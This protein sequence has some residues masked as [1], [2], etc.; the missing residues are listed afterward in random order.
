MI[1]QSED[2]KNG[3]HLIIQSMVDL[4]LTRKTIIALSYKNMKG[5]T[6]IPLEFNVN[7]EDI[8]ILIDWLKE[9][10]IDGNLVWHDNLHMD[11]VDEEKI[12]NF[13]TV[14]TTEDPEHDPIMFEFFFYKEVGGFRQSGSAS[15]SIF[16]ACGLLQK[17]MDWEEQ[18]V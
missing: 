2:N 10:L 3:P 1:F 5:E 12:K 13:V 17:L 6:E 4:D 16:R 14:S 15:I 18:N 8:L 11:I 7:R 9:C